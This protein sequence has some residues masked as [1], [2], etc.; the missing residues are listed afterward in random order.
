VPPRSGNMLPPA[1]SFRPVPVLARSSAPAFR[2]SR[3]LVA[4][5]AACYLLFM[6]VLASVHPYSHFLHEPG[7]RSPQIEALH[8]IADDC[9]LCLALATVGTGLPT[10]AAALVGWHGSSQPVVADALPL[11]VAAALRYE[12]RA[13][14]SLSRTPA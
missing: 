14:P 4:V 8:Q 9:D 3:P 2:S 10:P 6:Q 12:A 1:P 5:L 11:L 7:T 13:P